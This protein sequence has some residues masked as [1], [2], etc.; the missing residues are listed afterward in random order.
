MSNKVGC[1]AWNG[2]DIGE[3]GGMVLH[4]HNPPHEYTKWISLPHLAE[5][6]EINLKA[7]PIAIRTDRLPRSLHWRHSR[8]PAHAHIARLTVNL[9][10]CLGAIVV[11]GSAKS[12]SPFLPNMTLFMM[13][14]INR[15][16]D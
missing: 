13:P 4:C 10:Q 9:H 14:I 15:I 8:V 2:R 5:V 3:A 16:K 7:C 1:L 11:L 6:N 12:M